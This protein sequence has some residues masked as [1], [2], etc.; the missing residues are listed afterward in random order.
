MAETPQTPDR[1]ALLKD[2]LRAVEEMQAKLQAAERA[3]TEPIAVVGIGCRFPGGVDGPEAL[4]QLLRN[5]VDAV[6]EVPADR[7]SAQRYFDLDPELAAAKPV[8]HGAFLDGVDRFDA[9]FFGISR[10]EAVSMDPQHRLVLEVCWEALEHAGYAPRSLKDSLTGVFVGITAS[11]YWQHLRAADPTRLDVY[12]ATGNSHNAAAGRVAFALGLQGPALAVDTACSSSLSAVHLAC[13]SLRAGESHLALAGGVNTIHNADSFFAFHKWGF[14]AADGRC[15]TFDAS[16]DGFVRAEGC[17]FV[18]LKRLSDAIAD[19]DRILA[20]IRGSAMNQDGAT[21]GFTVPNGRAQEAVIRQALG[22]GGIAPASVGYVEAHGTGTSLGDPIELDALDAVLGEGRRPDQPLVVGSLKTNFG[23][24][25]SAAGIAGL[26]K[27]ILSL[28]H[29]EIPPHLHFRSLNPKAAVRHVSLVV[30]TAAR[31]WPAGGAPRIGSVSSFGI[32]GTNAHVVVEEAPAPRAASAALERPLHLL[33]VTGRDEQALRAAAARLGAHLAANPALP[34]A[35]VAFT[36]NA[37]RTALARRA[38]ITVRTIDEAR[39]GLDA[40]ARGEGDPRA[41]RGEAAVETTPRVAFLFTGQGAQY[42]GMGRELYDSQPAFREALDRCDAILRAGLDVPLL[43]ILYGEASSRIDETRYAQPALFAVEYALARMWQSWGVTPALLLGHSIGEYVAACVAGVFSL[44]DALGL[45]A[46]RGRLMQ[47]LPADGAMA[48]V[49][50]SEEAVRAPLAATGGRVA[51][52]AVNGPSSVVVAGPE[53]DV[54]RLCEQWSSEGVRTR[55]L[56]VS[57]AFHSPLMDPMLDAFEAVA[58][59][60]TYARPRIGVISNVTGRRATASELGTAAYWRAHVRATV[61]FAAGMQ[62]LADDGITAFIEIGPSATLLGLGQACAGHGDALWLPS[63]RRDRDAWSTLLESLGGLFVRGAGIDWKGFD[64]GYA[65]RKVAL[66]T[67]PF[68]RERYWVDARTPDASTPVQ[69]A[70]YELQWREAPLSSAAGS[71][72]ARAWI[73]LSDGSGVGDRL[74]A[75]LLKVGSPVVIVRRGEDPVAAIESAVRQQADLGGVVHLWSL[76]AEPN[77]QLTGDALAIAQRDGVETFVTAAQALLRTGARARVFSVTRGA[78]PALGGAVAQSPIWG[79]ARVIALEHPEI[80]GGSIDVDPAASADDAAAAVLRELAADGNDEVAYRSGTRRALRLARSTA[81]AV[82]PA[83][84]RAGVTYLVTGGA[85]GLGLAVAEWL[86]AAGATH[87]VLTSRRGRPA[88]GDALAAIEALERRGVNLRVVSAD[89][90]VRAQMEAVLREID[91]AGAPLGGVIH[92]AG[93]LRNDSVGEVTTE[94]VR[95][96]CRPKIAGAWILHELTRGL[97]LDL[98]VL[99]SSGAA[100]WGSRG[101]V[102]YGAANQ[103]LDALSHARR[104]E[105]LPATSINWGPWAETGMADAAGQRLMAQMGVSAFA[106]A[107]GIAAFAHA[108]STGLPQLVAAAVDWRVFGPIYRSRAPRRLLDELAPSESPERR[109]GSGDLA[110]RVV[111]ALPGDRRGVLIEALQ[112]HAGAVLAVE[113]AAPDPRKGLTELGM[114]SLMAVELRNRLQHAL[115]VALAPTLAFDCPTLDAMAEYLLG[116]VAPAAAAPSP[117]PARANVKA[118]PGLD[119]DVAQVGTMTQEEVRALLAGE[120][121]ALS[122][123]GI[124]EDQG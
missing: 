40:I 25:E 79:A 117:E 83:Q 105:G 97:P 5:G 88:A 52:A 85:S 57:H 78:A 119:A 48:A 30:P 32:S 31:P 50:A 9:G 81:A 82:K 122:L 59:D 49:W 46:A 38:A 121:A 55:S 54:A 80:W 7:W 44:E 64:A 89:V 21:S 104:A 113:G 35:D 17:G 71:G 114:D 75:A 112:Q 12:I 77:A 106:T 26:I 61:Q 6:T 118:A 99:F 93:V 76:D 24:M 101:L 29:G 109:T 42:A 115:G 123:D 120:L 56:T 14:M 41:L 94:Q 110:R 10:R 2:A 111:A 47:A 86:A 53:V 96:V 19:D 70:L 33:T 67:Y 63:L 91:A 27:V 103:F 108:L 60:V 84:I 100:I 107:D 15:K 92:A 51:L 98:F 20:V 62:A 22:N 3:R 45:V 116:L 1:R 34:I 28:Q 16:A 102:H 37:G 72:A 43:D 74:A 36:A 73:V 4:W 124:G 13:Q 8:L 68:Q 18:V 87:L 11:D 23:H 65:R 90:A 39:R 58:A 66:P 69:D 95:D